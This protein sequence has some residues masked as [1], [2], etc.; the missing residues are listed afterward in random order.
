MRTEKSL[1]VTFDK[2]LPEPKSS[3]LVED[4]RIDKPIVQDLNGSPSLQVNVSDEG[5]P[6]S[7]KL[8]ESPIGTSNWRLKKVV[9]DENS[10]EQSSTH[11]PVIVE[12]SRDLRRILGLVY[13]DL[14]LG[15]KAWIPFELEG[16]AFK[17]EGRVCYQ[18]R[19]SSMMYT[20]MDALHS[21]SYHSAIEALNSKPD[22]YMCCM[23]LMIILLNRELVEPLMDYHSRV[24]PR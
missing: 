18:V 2:S 10:L 22:S 16:E 9:G 15:G 3:P 21:T 19:Q 5:Y 8:I 20:S 13:H 4:N 23:H 1:N 12:V 7:L 24:V 14:Y 11:K 17:P 6:K